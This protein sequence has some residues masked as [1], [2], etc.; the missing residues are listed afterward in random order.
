MKKKCLIICTIIRSSW[1]ACQLQWHVV[2]SG[3]AA[4]AAMFTPAE[5]SCGTLYTFLLP[6]DWDYGK[7]R[8]YNTM[9]PRATAW[10]AWTATRWMSTTMRVEFQ[11]REI[12]ITGG[13]IKRWTTTGKLHSRMDE[14]HSIWMRIKVLQT[15]LRG[16]VCVKG[17]MCLPW[18]FISEEDISDPFFISTSS[19]AEISSETR[20]LDAYFMAMRTSMSPSPPHQGAIRMSVPHACEGHAC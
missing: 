16:E 12:N 10:W 11:R 20:C 8:D 6:S 1:I 2:A 13:I 4:S 14:F 3:W 7:D 18:Q 9:I 19:M 15:T 17:A 5:C